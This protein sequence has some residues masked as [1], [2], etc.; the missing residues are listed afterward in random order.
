MAIRACMLGIFVCW[1]LTAANA[2]AQPEPPSVYKDG[3]GAFHIDFTTPAVYDLSSHLSEV[4][5]GGLVREMH[6]SHTASGALTGAGHDTDG[7]D[8][9]V[10]H[11]VKGSC[12][13]KRGETFV[14]QKIK[15]IGSLSTDDPKEYRALS[16]FTGKM[17]GYGPDTKL[18]GFTETRSCLRFDYAPFSKKKIVVCTR[19][20]LPDQVFPHPSAGLWTIRLAFDDD[21]RNVF[22]SATVFISDVLPTKVQSHETTVTGRIGDDGEATFKLDPADGAPFGKITLRALVVPRQ[23]A[24][25]PELVEIL[26]VGGKILGQKFAEVF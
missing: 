24:T 12:K 5:D 11:E 4:T 7:A 1:L 2:T 22:G 18:V 23:G 9:S 16:V 13:T 21:G 25:P 6:V 8:Y 14:T 19:S 15:S 10:I 20:L 3:N 17:E 26:E